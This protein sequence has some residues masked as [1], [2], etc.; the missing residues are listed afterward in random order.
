[1]A[2]LD[3]NITLNGGEG[4]SAVAE[5]TGNNTPTAKD[6]AKSAFTI[7]QAT[8]VATRF[9]RQIATNTIGSIGTFT[10]NNILQE[11]VERGMSFVSRGI[12]VGVAF[13]ANPVLGAVAL[14]GEGI[15]VAF[16]LAQQQRKLEWQNV[17]ASELRRRAG[18]ESNKNRGGVR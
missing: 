1:M 3:I 2:D 15:D 11:R 4:A 8:R 16:K 13:I 7:D 5:T 17:A 12:G 6:N 18:Y 9:A 10:G 14:V